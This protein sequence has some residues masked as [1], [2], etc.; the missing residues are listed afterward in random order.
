[1]LF[2]TVDGEKFI[3]MLLFIVLAMRGMGKAWGMFDKDGS[4]HGAARNAVKEG[5]TEG[6]GGWLG[7]LWGRL[8]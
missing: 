6:K 7:K 2:A 1:M 3:F 5:I 4:I 8:K